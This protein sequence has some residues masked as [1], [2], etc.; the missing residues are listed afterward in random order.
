MNVSAPKEDGESGSVVSQH[1]RYS[2]LFSSFQMPSLLPFNLVG[3]AAV[4][5]K[6]KLG[7]RPRQRFVEDDSVNDTQPVGGGS[8]V[9]DSRSQLVPLAEADSAVTSIATKA[10]RRRPLA[11]S[12]TK[13]L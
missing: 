10:R 8:R 12:G 4:A 7:R 9:E 11:G 2:S 13:N 5:S 3:G 1:K 6:P